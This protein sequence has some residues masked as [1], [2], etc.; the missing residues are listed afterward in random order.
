MPSG[1]GSTGNLGVGTT[2]PNYRL[3]VRGNIALGDTSTNPQI[4]FTGASVNGFTNGYIS[5]NAGTNST[6]ALT[7]SVPGNNFEVVTGYN[8]RVV[9]ST[10]NG[11]Y[12]YTN[13]GSGTYTNRLTL[14]R[15]GN[16]TISGT[17]TEQ[18][19][20]RYKENIAPVTAALEKVDQLQPV[21]Y[22]KKGS[23]TKEI[24]LIAEDV[25]DVYPEFVLC[26][27]NGEPVGIHYS[28]LTAVLIESVK[29][30]KTR[31]QELEKRN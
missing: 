25:F 2:S 8:E 27:D 10:G 31:I 9:L 7:L 15:T 20:L 26:D 28:R 21:S 29:E 22:N 13:N 14:D 23:S 5:W 18:S 1:A 16:L 3:D 17:L 4:I 11:L 12:V 6:A 30:L 19:A 24:G